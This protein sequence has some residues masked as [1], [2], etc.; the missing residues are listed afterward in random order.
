MT[1]DGAPTPAKRLTVTEWVRFRVRHAWSLLVRL[2]TLNRQIDDLDERLDAAVKARDDALESL[3]TSLL[4][5][6]DLSDLVHTFALTAHE[7]A[8]NCVQIEADLATLKTER[9]LV[10]D[11]R[12]TALSELDTSIESVTANRVEQRTTLRTVEDELNGLQRAEDE[13]PSGQDAALNAAQE[14]QKALAEG[15][16][17]LEAALENLETKR[18]RRALAF[19]ARLDDL[20]AQLREVESNLSHLTARRRATLIDLGREGLSLDP[21]NLDAAQRATA[22]TTLDGVRVLRRERNESVS[23]RASLDLGPLWRMSGTIVLTTIVLGIL[24]RILS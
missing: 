12:E 5:R 22:V 11:E 13:P 24:W 19:D 21:E 7:L 4:A 15:L 20:D 2:R 10:V 3:G 16:D 18:E 23:A 6:D 17:S 9:V 14:R 1:E 8:E